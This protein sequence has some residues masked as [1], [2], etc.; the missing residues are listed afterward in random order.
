MPNAG[1]WRAELTGRI[2]VDEDGI[3]NSHCNELDIMACGETM[4]EVVRST[5]D[6]IRVYIES[7]VEDG[8]IGALME[9]LGAPDWPALPPFVT[10]FMAPGALAP[11]VHQLAI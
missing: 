1:A 3:F 4:D 6:G 7:C 11:I 5:L 10:R 8:T 2:W 9:R